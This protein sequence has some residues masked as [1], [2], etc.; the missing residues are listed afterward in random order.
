MVGYLLPVWTDPKE[1]DSYSEDEGRIAVQVARLRHRV[2]LPKVRKME[3]TV[4]YVRTSRPSVYINR[5][6]I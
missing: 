3:D 5:Q 4:K 1:L 2:V 6:F